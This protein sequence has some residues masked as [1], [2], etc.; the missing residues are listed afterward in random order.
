M[1]KIEKIE[2]LKSIAKNGKDKYINNTVKA[3][4]KQLNRQQI[5]K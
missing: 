4:I 5:N 2:E 1:S 3:K